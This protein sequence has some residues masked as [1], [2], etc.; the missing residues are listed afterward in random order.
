MIRILKYP[1]SIV[2]KQTISLPECA[3]ILTVQTQ[4]E[5]P[6]IWVIINTDNKT[7]EEKEI[8]T[9]GTGHE[10]ED[11]DSKK[12]LGT[13]QINGAALVFHVFIGI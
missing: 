11:V 6:F 3:E 2:D 1:L 9:H 8:Y 12:Y 10:I 5:M 7:T 4:Q 13:Y